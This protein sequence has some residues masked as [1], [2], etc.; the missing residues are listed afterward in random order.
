MANI[1]INLSKIQYNAKVLQTILDAK[2]IQFTPVIKSIAGDLQ[3]VQKLIELG[4]THFADSRLENIRQL[5]NFDCS[6]T[7]LRSTQLSQLDN[8][9]KDTQISIQTELNTIIELN[10]IAQHLNIK[11]QVI[12][13]VDWKDGRE[14]VL[15]YDVV[16]YIETILNLSHIQLV[17]V[18]FNF[19]CFKSSSPIEDDVFMINKFVSAIEREIGY[20][21]KIVSGGNSS[22]LPLTMYNDLGKINELRIGETLFRGVDTTTDKP[23]SHLYQDAIVLEAEILEIKPRMNSHTKQSY[24]QAIVDIGYIDTDTTHI[25]PI[26]NDIQIIGASSDHLMIDLN[27]QDHYQIGNKIQF[28]LSYEALS[29]S[30]YNKNLEK[31]YVTDTKVEMMIHSFNE[32]FCSTYHINSNI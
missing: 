32:P 12:L 20:R 26:A 28:Q 1:K 2:H 24:L 13:M 7:I 22:M 25:S 19:M 4:I 31:V 8:M 27:N 10:R 5:T 11:H 16:K 18:S 21:M 17:G 14:G 9:I 3:I 29:R 30:M 23:V 6:F 15:T